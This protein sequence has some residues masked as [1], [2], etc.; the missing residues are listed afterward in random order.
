ME[1]KEDEICIMFSGGLDSTLSAVIST[2]KSKKLHL[3]TFDNG[4]HLYF[5]K[6]VTTVNKLRKY[7]YKNEF[8]HKI[9][10]IRDL[11]KILRKNIKEELID[12]KSPLIIDICCRLSMVT[13]TIIY[14]LENN[15]SNSADGS[16]YE[17]SMRDNRFI[18]FK[19]GA[20]ENSSYM[21]EMTKL[22][23]KY[24]I[25]FYNPVYNFGKRKNRKNELKKVE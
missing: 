23:R 8:I 19:G 15:I 25:I 1:N 20:I 12:Y 16:S 10:C 17:Q 24:G 14:C 22:F 9:I 13:K 21:G 18:G 3:L 2:N 6:A 11:I 4:A 7:F 5:K